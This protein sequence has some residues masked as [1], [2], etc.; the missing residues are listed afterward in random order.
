MAFTVLLCVDGSE[1]G[2]IAVAEGLAVLARHDRL[3]VATVIE[4]VDPTLV[5]GT[6]MAGG[7]ISP[8]ESD[9]LQDDRLIAAR[10]MLESTCTRLGL[11]G[12][13]QTILEGSPGPALCQ[14]AT[15]LPASVVVVG[16]RGHGGLRRAVLGSVS[17]HIVRNAPCPVVTRTPA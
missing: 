1:L 11:V 12:A 10:A 14:L 8:D 6:G 4:A 5:V 15:D 17:D 3:V 2:E 9:Q 16:A 13:E 7:V